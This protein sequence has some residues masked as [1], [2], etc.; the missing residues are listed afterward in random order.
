MKRGAPKI[1]RNA[2][3][4]AALKIRL[5]ALLRLLLPPE[6]RMENGW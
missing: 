3:K 4:I 6:I 5:R 2:K 1:K